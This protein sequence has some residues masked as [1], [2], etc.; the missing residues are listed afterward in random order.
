MLLPI[1]LSSFGLNPT[2][3]V[4][5]LILIIGTIVSI[6]WAPE[7]K[8]LSLSEAGGK[9]ENAEPNSRTDFVVKNK[10]TI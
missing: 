5:T 8:F 2:M 10:K 1:S 7:T 9:S 6:A 3:F 4:I